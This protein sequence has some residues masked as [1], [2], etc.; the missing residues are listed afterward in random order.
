MP[1]LPDLYEW[2]G[3][4]P[5]PPH[6]IA[7]AAVEQARLSPCDKSKRGAAIYAFGPNVGVGI[8]VKG[9]PKNTEIVGLGHNGPP[10]RAIACTQDAACHRTCGALCVHAEA[11]ALEHFT[12]HPYHE[13]T[14]P[15]TRYFL[16]HAKVQPTQILED[17]S[18][19]GYEIAPGGGPS[20]VYCSKHILDTYWV[21]GVWLYQFSRPEVARWFFY[22]SAE[23]HQLSV[24]AYRSKHLDTPCTGCSGRGER[25]HND[26]AMHPCSACRGSGV[27]R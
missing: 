6:V 1:S 19:A 26:G 21:S 25:L 9:M 5:G 10:Q 13:V 14:P 4:E 11:R 16:V 17:G 24:A 8:A 27:A 12:E 7:H 18:R 23:F 22:E 15:G 20:C 2:W 3:A